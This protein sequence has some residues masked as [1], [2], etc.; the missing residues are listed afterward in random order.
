MV[1]DPLRH[2]EVA[3]SDGGDVKIDRRRP[4]RPEH[5]SPHL[6][7]LLRNAAEA[8]IPPD[9]AP[10][11]DRT[12]DDLGPAKGILAGLGLAIPLWGL[13]GLAVWWVLR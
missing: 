10:V 2:D 3:A 4:G 7:P 12:Q 13:I 9:D 5:V 11:A 6:I 8:E 1:D